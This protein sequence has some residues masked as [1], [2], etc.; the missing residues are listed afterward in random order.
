[1]HNLLWPRWKIYY[2][3][4]IKIAEYETDIIIDGAGIG[5]VQHQRECADKETVDGK[6]DYDNQDYPARRT[7]YEVQAGRKGWLHLV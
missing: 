4:Q 7:S 3:L 6:A 1:M 2:G 5:N